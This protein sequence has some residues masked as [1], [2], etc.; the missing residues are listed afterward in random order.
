MNKKIF[1]L[2]DAKQIHTAKWVDYFVKQGHEVHLA[3]FTLTNRTITPNVHFLTDKK[4]NPKGGNYHY[5]SSLK[6]LASLLKE[7]EPDIINAHFSYSMGFLALLAQKMSGVSAEFSVVCHG[8]DV[9][10]PPMPPITNQIN[11]YVL[12]NSDKIF[13]VSS[14]IR[15]K[16]EGFGIEPEKIFVGQYGI[17]LDVE[18]KEKDIDILSNRTY[19]PN[20]RIEMMLDY[21][22]E[23]DDMKLNVVFVLPDVKDDEFDVL[24]K[25]YKNVKFYKPMPYDEMINLVNRSK[26]YI[27]ATKSDGTSLSLFEAMELGCIPLVS[28]IISNRSLILDSV[29]GFLFYNKEQFLDKLVYILNNYDEIAQEIRN[30]NKNLISEIGDYETQ[31]QKHEEFLLS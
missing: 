16:I 31:M 20:A 15:D 30:I 17:D 14:Q 22:E 27:S 7:I 4:K 10:I 25:R 2:A 26:V 1:F 29:N 6:Q 28:D 9:L 8:T 12:R 19:E 5:F 3:T 13:A 24:V 23:L 21:L 18:S 11:K